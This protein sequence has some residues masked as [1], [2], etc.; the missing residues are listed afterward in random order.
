MRVR[1]IVAAVLL[2]ACAA[3]ADDAPTPQGPEVSAL[4]LRDATGR[5]VWVDLQVNTFGSQNAQYGHLVAR[6]VGDGWCARP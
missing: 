6:V 4:F 3:C 1:L 5:C 2:L